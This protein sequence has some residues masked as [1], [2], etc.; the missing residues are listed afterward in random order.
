M[1]Q[2]ASLQKWSVTV[3]AKV[4]GEKKTISAFGRDE[5][6][7]KQ[8]ALEKMGDQNA[9][10]WRAVSATKA[11]VARDGRSVVKYSAVAVSDSPYAAW[12][13]KVRAYKDGQ[14]VE[15]DDNRQP[16]PNRDAALAAAKRSAQ[17]LAQRE[18][19]TEIAQE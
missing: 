17:A 2:D 12:R 14:F 13:I 11:E 6:S 9:G 5:A 16:W 4:G 19:I 10:K 8:A 1:A 18:G 7:A 15:S 3:E